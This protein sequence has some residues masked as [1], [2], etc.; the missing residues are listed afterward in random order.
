M[1]IKFRNIISPKHI[2]QAS[3]E[4]LLQIPFQ[5]RTYILFVGVELT[6]MVFYAALLV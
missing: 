2:G 4:I 5:Y 1:Q 6:L 3:W